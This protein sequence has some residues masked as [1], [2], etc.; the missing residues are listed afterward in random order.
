MPG[1]LFHGYFMA[2]DGASTS[3]WCIPFVWPTRETINH[4]PH[5][6]NNLASGRLSRAVLG[7]RRLQASREKDPQQRGAGGRDGRRRRGRNGNRAAPPTTETDE[8]PPEPAA[9]EST[10]KES[11]ETESNKVMLGSDELFAGIP[12]EGTS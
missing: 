3:T 11:S 9:D 2:A 1:L 10:E 8:A 7:D 6:Q 4:D 5:A 12:G